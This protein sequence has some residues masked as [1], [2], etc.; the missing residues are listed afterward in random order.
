MPI[1]DTAR[2][3]RTTWT[4]GWSHIAMRVENLEEAIAYLD[5][6]GITWGG[7]VMNAFGGGKVRSLYDS[8]GNMLQI[9]ERQFN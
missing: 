6:K 9:L 1:D 2:P 5:T 3:T 4:P 8:E 7:E